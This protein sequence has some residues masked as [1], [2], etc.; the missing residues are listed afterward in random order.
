MRR[1]VL[2]LVTLLSLGAGLACDPCGAMARVHSE[3]CNDG[4][5]ESCAWLD[6]NA[7]PGIYACYPEMR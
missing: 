5:V 7:I 3:R 6:E 1:L 2:A 4:D